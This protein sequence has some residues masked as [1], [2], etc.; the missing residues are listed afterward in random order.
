MGSSSESGNKNAMK[1]VLN[2]KKP[3]QFGLGATAAL[4]KQLF[5]IFLQ[6]DQVKNQLLGSFTLHV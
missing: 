5:P 2:E 4:V 3:S 6:L 1:I